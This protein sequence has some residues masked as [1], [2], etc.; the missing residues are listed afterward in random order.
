MIGW[1]IIIV[2][3]LALCLI[4]VGIAAW[5]LSVYYNKQEKKLR[6]E[7]EAHRKILDG[8]YDL[9]LIHI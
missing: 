5:V 2:V 7:A 1:I 3:L 9:S 4:P 8:T 6:D